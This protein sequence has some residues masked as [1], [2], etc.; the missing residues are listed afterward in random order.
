MYTD[1]FLALK[2]E[3]NSRGHPILAALSYAFCPTAARWWV[4]GADPVLPFDPVWQALE[5]AASGE[6]MKA[7]LLRYGMETALEKAVRY[8]DQVDAYRRTHQDTIAPELFPSFPQPRF[9]MNERFGV[10]NAINNMGGEWNNFFVYVRTWAFLME[11]WE[12]AARLEVPK[13]RKERL[14][15][16]LSG[17]RHPA[18]FPAMVWEKKHGRATRIVIGLLVQDNEQDALRF[19]I[20]RQAGPEGKKPWA[21]PPE[22]WA[23]DRVTGE[24]DACD[25][26]IPTDAIG[27]IVERLADMAKNGP[28]PPLNAFQHP[29]RCKQCG[30]HAQCFMP[31]GDG[32][33]KK[34]QYE[35][36]SLALKF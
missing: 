5:D 24:A 19:S 2:D 29:S 4:A 17:F 11:D 20:V 26:I 25:L 14:G 36:S 23:F 9:D 1:L 28:Y 12:T 10:Y 22:T 13:I 27:G 30:Y 16:T 31:N 32:K 15:M 35:V 34:T 18:R 8:I 6:T 21:A 7:A 33:W 3:K